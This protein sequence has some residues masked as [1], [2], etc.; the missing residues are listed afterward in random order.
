MNDGKL[1]GKAVIP[2]S[3]VNATL[4]PSI[5]LPNTQLGSRGYGEIKP[6]RNARDSCA[7]EKTRRSTTCVA[8]ST[9]IATAAIHVGAGT[10]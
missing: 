10:S 1:E 4:A 5:A 3:I 8:I 9:R 2:A 7:R 6:A